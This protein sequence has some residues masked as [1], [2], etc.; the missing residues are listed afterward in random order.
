MV[1]LWFIS[2]CMCVNLNHYAAS[3]FGLILPLLKILC[4][5]KNIKTIIITKICNNIITIIITKNN[6]NCKV[7]TTKMLSRYCYTV[8][9]LR[10]IFLNIKRLSI[11]WKATE[12][13]RTCSVADT[14]Q[15]RETLIRH[16]PLSEQLS[17]YCICVGRLSWISVYLLRV[18]Y[19]VHYGKVHGIN[20]EMDRRRVCVCLCLRTP[21]IYVCEIQT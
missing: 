6:N 7:T 2:S 11:V 15:I 19:H 12:W 5:N 4:N 1:P 18:H 10:Y 17:N 9:K 13:Y 20:S 3:I 21:M 14:V 8:T 16:N